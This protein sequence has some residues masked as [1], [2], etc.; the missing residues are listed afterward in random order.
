MSF[1]KEISVPFMANQALHDFGPDY[2]SDLIYNCP[3]C[4]SNAPL[5]FSHQGLCPCCF[6]PGPITRRTLWPA[7]S[8]IQAS[9]QMFPCPAWLKHHQVPLAHHHSKPSF[10]PY[11]FFLVRYYLPSDICSVF[12]VCLTVWSV[13]LARAETV[14]VVPVCI[15]SCLINAWCPVGAQE[16]FVE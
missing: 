14:H 1:L 7:P 6:L 11:Y 10:P 5:S 4:F 8:C 12:S 2:L 9:A 13:R 15:A 16:I 3:F